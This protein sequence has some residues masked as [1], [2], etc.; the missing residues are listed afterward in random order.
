MVVHAR[1]NFLRQQILTGA[2]ANISISS[3]LMTGKIKLKIK[4]KVV[5]LAAS[6]DTPTGGIPFIFD[7]LGSSLQTTKDMVVVHRGHKYS[8]GW[9][10]ACCWA[11]RIH[12]AQAGSC[13]AAVASNA[14]AVNFDA[15]S[16]VASRAVPLATSDTVTAPAVASHAVLAAASLA[17]PSAAPHERVAVSAPVVASDAVPSAVTSDAVFAIEAPAAAFCAESLHAAGIVMLRYLPHGSPALSAEGS[18]YSQRRSCGRPACPGGAADPS[19]NRQCRPPGWVVI[20]SVG[21]QSLG[22]CRGS[23]TS[24]R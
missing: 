2:S 15:V 16:A 12:N 7:V 14:P 4:L 1:L 22:I 8:N 24:P 18:L 20:T 6:S 3:D 10:E 19:C 5:L 17:V 13:A 9:S 11:N 23:W 21:A